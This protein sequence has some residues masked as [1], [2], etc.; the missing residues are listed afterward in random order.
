MGAPTVWRRSD[1]ETALAQQPLNPARQTTA[2][3]LT[4]DDEIDAFALNESISLIVQLLKPGERGRMHGHSF[5][6]LYFV[7]KGHGTSQLDG[8]SLS[9]SAGDSFYVPPWVEHDLQNL[10][11]EEDAI[12]HSVQN[13]PAHALGGTLM[14]KE[15]GGEYTLVLSNGNIG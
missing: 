8:E 2:I 3:A 7:L 6:H 4:R 10:S 13:L 9:W 14:R 12:V 5:W 1:V 11:Q 15:A